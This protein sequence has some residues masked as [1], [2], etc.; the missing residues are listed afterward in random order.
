MDMFK[1]EV[2]FA[3]AIC[4]LWQ[5]FCRAREDLDVKESKALRRF[6]TKE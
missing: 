3:M 4:R 5:L 6:S 1:G 2:M